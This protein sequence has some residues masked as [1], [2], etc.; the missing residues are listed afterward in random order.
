MNPKCKLDRTLA[1][2]LFAVSLLL[3]C[4]IAYQP[5]NAKDSAPT[6]CLSTLKEGAIIFQITHSP[7]SAAIQ[8]ATGSKY[9]HC[10]ILFKNKGRLHV[11]EPIEPAS[12]PPLG[13][14]LS[15]GITGNPWVVR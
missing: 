9:T 10:C 6:P 7:Q 2:V 12:R 1:P 5:A 13:K 8:L 4:L 11:F 14:C 15:R 3:A